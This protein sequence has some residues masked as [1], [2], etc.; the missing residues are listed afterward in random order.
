MK[1]AVFGQAYKTHS[2]QY[3][4]N[5]I[6]LLKEK[7][8]EI[9]VFDKVYTLIQNRIEN[10]YNSFSSYSDLPADTDYMISVGG[11]G[12]M[13]S[14]AK[15]IKDKKIPV[16]GINTGRLGFLATIQKDEMKQAVEELLLKNYSIQKRSLLKVSI[17][18]KGK[19]SG[20]FALNEVT[21][22]RKNTTTMITIDTYLDSEF[23]NTY[24][25]DGLIIAT[26]TGSTGYSLSCSGPI[27]TPEVQALVI[28]PIA[29]HNLSTRPLIIK[30]NTH[31]KLNISSR[32]EEF[33]LSLDSKVIPVKMGTDVFIKK[34]DFKLYMIELHNQSFIKTLREK[35]LWGKDTRN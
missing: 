23:L 24:W 27:V 2:L 14:A 21:V 13:L 35:L 26:P 10:H 28:T 16:I 25:A 8:C 1:I 34:T 31:I 29:P 4:V 5:L 22:S 6:N 20:Y 7:S 15:Y 17:A 3:I 12:T 19:D 11:D 32:E 30:D 33:L 18:S 9:I